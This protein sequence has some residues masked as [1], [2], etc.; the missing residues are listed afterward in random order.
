MPLPKLPTI[1]PRNPKAPLCSKRKA[2]SA[3]TLRQWKSDIEQLLRDISEW[4]HSK[5]WM[6][7]QESREHSETALGTYS[8]ND[9][10]IKVP[11][12]LLIVEVRG[13][14][15]VG[16]EGRVDLYAWPALRR[17][18]LIRQHGK[19]V[20]KTDDGIKWPEAWGQ[21]TFL[22]LAQQLASP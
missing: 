6:V 12:G 22:D 5:G 17:M 14:N 9:L 8:V 2:S 15:V 20:V 16:A 11:G 19:W 13:R 7:V 18:M 10:N 3:A 4:A 1:S 21:R